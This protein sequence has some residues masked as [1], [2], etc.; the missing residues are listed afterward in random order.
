M[1]KITALFH[2]DALRHDYVTEK[3]MPFLFS[4]AKKGVRATLIPPFGF[5]PDGAYLTGSNPEDYEGGTHF[6]YNEKNEGIPFTDRL[7]QWL[8]YL[9]MYIQYPLR[10]I[11]QA[12]ISRAGS[13]ERIRRQPFIGQIPFSFMKYF[14]FCE[15]LMP[16]QPG[17]AKSI[18]TVYDY[19][20]SK[21]H[22]FF[23][24]GYPEFPSASDGA[25][26]RFKKDF[27][28]DVRFAFFLI[29]DL[30]IAG[31]EFGPDS[32]QRRQAAAKV[33]EVVG[34]IHRHL[35]STYDVVDVIAFG[36]HG[37]V[38]VDKYLDFRSFVRQLPL[39]IGKDYV[40]F[41]DSTFARFWF[42]NARAESL[43][44]EKLE[45]LDG[46]TIV[47]GKDKAEYHINFKNRKFGDCIF[48]TDGGAMLFPNFWHVRKKKKGMH[49]YRRE[50]IDNHG[51][52][53][54]HTTEKSMHF[55]APMR[56]MSDVFQTVIYSIFGKENNLRR[57]SQGAPVQL[58]VK[59][60]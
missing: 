41:L 7:P 58:S 35:T 26:D 29:S 28:G 31:H 14:D 54:F 36:D 34:E 24:H 9:N 20:R 40:Y 43:T 4:L 46:G 57:N 47:S 5:E 59:E 3:E 21:G 15:R 25:R 22:G 60:A 50:V 8:D 16:Y 37:M 18:P 44:R 45:G 1:K 51:A 2:L 48:W 6:V 49:G 19:L 10:K 52:L 30:D 13:T 17:F 53:V 11:L 38:A 27:R 55:E 33:D 56:D 32:H 42:F 23:Y 39:T 12:L